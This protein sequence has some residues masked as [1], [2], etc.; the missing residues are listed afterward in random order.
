[1]KLNARNTFKIINNFNN[2]RIEKKNGIILPHEI[3]V[4]TV[5]KN[6]QTVMIKIMIQVLLSDNYLMITNS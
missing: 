2:L 4:Y 6:L 3:I 1:M 5:L